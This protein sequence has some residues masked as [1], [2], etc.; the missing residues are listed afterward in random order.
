[1]ENSFFGLLV[2]L[3]KKSSLSTLDLKYNYK[4]CVE[5]T[6]FDIE[7]VIPVSL[8][9]EEVIPAIEEEISPAV[10]KLLKQFFIYGRLKQARISES[11]VSD[12]IKT[13]C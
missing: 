10:A 9:I 13:V 11:E 5:D 3:A 4:D 6:N 12:F 2:E 1:M 7:K 8:N